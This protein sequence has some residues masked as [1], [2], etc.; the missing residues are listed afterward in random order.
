MIFGVNVLC[1]WTFWDFFFGPQCLLNLTIFEFSYSVQKWRV[2]IGA[3]DGPSLIMAN[4][5]N[6]QQKLLLK[7]RAK[8]IFRISLRVNCAIFLHRGLKFLILKNLLFSGLFDW[9]RP[10]LCSIWGEECF[11]L[12]W[13]L[14]S[15]TFPRTL[16][17]F[18]VIFGHFG[19]KS[20]ARTLY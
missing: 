2:K 4:Y 8:A 1:N 13:R 17:F 20:R 9:S 19:H 6:F 14:W 7:T 18:L 5:I 12:I 16:V 10:F 3:F 15:R 11:E